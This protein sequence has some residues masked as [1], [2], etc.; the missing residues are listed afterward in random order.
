MSQDSKNSTIEIS[1]EEANVLVVNSVET[2]SI[3]VEAGWYKTHRTD[4]LLIFLIRSEVFEMFEAWRKD[5]V[6]QTPS[7]VGNGADVVDGEKEDTISHL[8]MLLDMEDEVKF[9]RLFENFIKDT[10]QDEL[11]DIYIRIM[12]F[13]GYKKMT[14]D[15]ENDIKRGINVCATPFTVIAQ[16]DSILY[17][18]NNDVEK[19]YKGYLLNC[20]RIIQNFCQVNLYDLELH[21][22]LK[23][24]YNKL[25][26]RK[27]GGKKV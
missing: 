20:C 22:N 11:A 1:Q 2:H 21:V 13:I 25:R 14:F 6:S 4:S 26:G 16:L 23:L 15:V 18:M 12:D 17:C 24:K 10:L 27:H 7:I 19:E 9:K 8:S 3:Q 5:K